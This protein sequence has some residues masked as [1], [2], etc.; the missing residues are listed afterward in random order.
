MSNE[1]LLLLLLM[2]AVV[3]MRVFVRYHN[4]ESD[5]DTL[6]LLTIICF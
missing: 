6:S 4:G 5:E 2:C 3:C 1:L